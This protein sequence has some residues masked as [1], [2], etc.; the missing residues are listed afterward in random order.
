MSRKVFLTRLIPIVIGISFWPI[1]E[2]ASQEP[3]SG[4]T[5]RQ[6]Q[7]GT[8]HNRS[9]DEPIIVSMKELEKHPQDYYGKT[10]TVDG[11]LHRTF[12]DNM[13]TIDDGGFFR[14]QDIL[15][16]S[17][18]P[19]A[20]A[21]VPLEGSLKEGK[22]VRVTGVVQPYDR[23]KLE[24]AYGPLHLESREGY[25]FTKNPVLIIDGTR[26]AELEIPPIPPQL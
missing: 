14:D 21:V 26:A 20:E 10:V 6:S 16:I 24:C 9:F 13:F 22:D 23:G 18:V 17:A 25:F 5:C 2:M 11:E 7:P 19:K 12:T 4:A 8:R 1:H 15:V 3:T